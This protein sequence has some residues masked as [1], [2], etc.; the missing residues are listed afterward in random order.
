[1]VTTIM[2]VEDEAALAGVVRD[3][4][5]RE[6]YSVLTAGDGQAALDLARVRQPDVVIL[7]VMLPGLD[8]VE[9]CRRLRQFSDTYVLMLTAICPLSMLVMALSMGRSRGMRRPTQPSAPAAPAHL[10]TLQARRVAIARDIA[11]LEGG[12]SPVVREAAAIAEAAVAG[13]LPGTQPMR[14]AADRGRGGQR[15]VARGG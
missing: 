7:D 10:P 13:G 15:T 4:L 9:V 3:Y 1:M 8:G 2:V 5:A 14:A 12:A 6:D 11:R